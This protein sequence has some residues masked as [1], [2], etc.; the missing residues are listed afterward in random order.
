[1]LAICWVYHP[2]SSIEQLRNI[3]NHQRDHNWLNDLSMTPSFRFGFWEHLLESTIF[4][5]KIDGFRFRFSQTN[6]SIEIFNPIWAIPT[7]GTLP[8]NVLTYATLCSLTELAMESGKVELPR[9]LAAVEG[10]G[11][12]TLTRKLWRAAVGQ[13]WCGSPNNKPSRFH[14][15]SVVY[16][17]VY[18]IIVELPACHEWKR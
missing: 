16:G 7:L 10:K 2:I 14:C 12:E 5:G 11:L 17:W 8:G 6:Q 18:P 1:M 13:W 9:M 15:G 3:W 4:N